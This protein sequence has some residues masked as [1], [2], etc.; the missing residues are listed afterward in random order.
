MAWFDSVGLVGMDLVF[1]QGV[2][3]LF[4]LCLDAV[5]VVV[6]LV[7]SVD[8]VEVEEGMFECIY[9]IVVDMCDGV[10]CVYFKIAVHE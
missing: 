9:A 7:R 5:D 1:F 2:F 8:G 4:L 6:L 10:G 3:D